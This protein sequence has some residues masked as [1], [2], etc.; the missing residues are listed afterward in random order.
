MKA[1]SNPFL[2]CA[3]VPAA[4]FAL[5]PLHAADVSTAGGVTINS[6]NP[7]N[8]Y[9]D[10]GILTVSGGFVALGTSEAAPHSRQVKARMPDSTG[11][12]RVRLSLWM[13]LE[14]GLKAAESSRLRAFMRCVANRS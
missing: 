11:D 1:R 3:L 7:G 10:A 4:F 14:S 12:F 13:C 6:N 5:A 9:I 2:F 8:K